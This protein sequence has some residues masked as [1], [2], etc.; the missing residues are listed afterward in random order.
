[1]AGNDPP[2]T[3]VIFEASAKDNTIRA[4]NLPNGI[5]NNATTPTNRII[6]SRPAGF[7]VS[8]PPFPG[9]GKTLVN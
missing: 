1:M 6:L 5:T 2:G 4:L 8:T 9:S 7:A 3:D